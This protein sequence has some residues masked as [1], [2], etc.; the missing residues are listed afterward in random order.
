MKLMNIILMALFIL[1]SG[2]SL[3]E[4]RLF[5]GDQN[6]AESTVISDAQ[7][8][9]EVTFEYKIQPNDRVSIEVFNQI[10]SSQQITS[11][12]DQRSSGQGGQ[13]GETEGFL[14]TADGTINLPLIGPVKLEGMTEDQAAKYLMEEYKIYLRNPYAIV[15]IRNQRIIMIGEVNKPG[16]I[17]IT[18]GTMNLIEAIARSG[19]MTDWAMRTHIV[20][21]RGDLRK[22]EVRIIDLTNMSA[23]SLSSL[24]LRDKDIVYVQPRSAKG[25]QL[26]TQEVL[27][28]FSL[29]SGILTPFVLIDT[30]KNSNN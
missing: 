5:Q 26:F 3:K 9:E 16:V 30:L 4:Y 23:L 2:C 6:S 25:M 28:P 12:V 27:P 19:D 13:R 1:S 14:V 17:P 10:G 24:Y 22:P 11:I 21:L 7:Y 8:N 20:V 18:N 29:I 15:R